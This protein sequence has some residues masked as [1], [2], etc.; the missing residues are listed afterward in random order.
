MVAAVE[1][2]IGLDLGQVRDPSAVAVVERAEVQGEWDPVMFARRKVVELRLRYVERMPL[3]TPYAEVVER[4]RAMTRSAEL[5]GRCQLVVDATG[6]GR[7]VVELLQG[8]DLGCGVMPVM[9]TGGDT[10]SW[11]NGY[12]R[13]PKRDMIVGL[14]VLLQN[15]SLQIA[16]GLEYGTALLKEMGQMQVKISVD[17]NEQFG[18][19]REGE[20]DDLVFAVALACWAVRKMW[21]GSRSGYWV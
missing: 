8:A 17:E 10:E 13:A 18:A 16:A 2:L 11:A 19:W 14:Q 4:V 1:C 12:Y 9:I 21:P 15:G 6:V 20:H 5:A 7:P 3:G